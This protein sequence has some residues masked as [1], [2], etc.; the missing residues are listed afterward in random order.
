M[1]LSLLTVSAGIDFW[2][3]AAQASLLIVG[4]V[5]L[6]KGADWFVD[7]A[8]MIARKFGI[9]QI[10]IG[11]TIVAFGTSDRQR[12]RVKYHE[13]IPYTWLMRFV[14]AD[15]GAKKY[16]VY[17]NTFCSCHYLSSYG[18]G[19]DRQAALLGRRHNNVADVY[20][21]FCISHYAFKKGQERYVG[22]GRR[23]RG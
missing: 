13:Y 4:F 12:L 20:N 3:I 22:A 2:G 14:H 18:D 17:R 19:R 11:L 9:P 8:S 21:L 7:G 16:S 1:N 15:G 5:M 23:I 10:V 6:I